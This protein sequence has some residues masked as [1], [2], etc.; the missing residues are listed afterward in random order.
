MR[1]SPTASRHRTDALELNEW[2]GD[3]WETRRF[4][5]GVGGGVE[6]QGVIRGLIRPKVEKTGENGG[7][8]GWV[9]HHSKSKY[10]YIPYILIIIIMIIDNHYSM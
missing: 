8:T 3:H 10:V 6:L 4:E 7:V 2:M 9:F 5:S 1:M